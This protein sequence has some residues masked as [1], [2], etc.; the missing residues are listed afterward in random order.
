MDK[1][2]DLCKRDAVHVINPDLGDPK[3]FRELPP[4]VYIFEN[5]LIQSL[6]QVKPPYSEKKLTG[7]IANLWHSG[8]WGK[9]FKVLCVDSSGY[10][11]LMIP[12]TDPKAQNSFE[13]ITVNSTYYLKPLKIFKDLKPDF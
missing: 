6:K 12:N 8:N 5:R 11:I 4:L 3:K 1:N 7:L 9:N 10:K 2:C 13:L